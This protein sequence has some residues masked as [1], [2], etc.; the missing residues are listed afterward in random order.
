MPIEDN[1][2]ETPEPWVFDQQVADHF[3]DML[4]RSIPGHDAMRDLVD[5]LAETV[6]GRL[7]G[8]VLYDLGCSRGG[9][10][11]R[12]A[13]R[14]L[15]GGW[16]VDFVG[17]EVSPPMLAAAAARFAAAPRVR[18]APTDLRQADPDRIVGAS[19]VL[20]VLTLQFVPVE[21]R[22]RI[23]REAHVGLRQGGALILV[24]KVLG[25]E[26]DTNALLVERYHAMKRRNGYS[27]EA[28]RR[29]ALSLEGVLV[30]LTAAANEE[31]LRAAG[32]RVVE[33]FWRH[34]NFAGWIA[35]R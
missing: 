5:D 7:S 1:L 20:S 22:A 2:A 18:I 25:P 29:K 13:S 26:H 31:A 8:G 35:L 30:P 16:L 24:E 23:L 9:A 6:L 14:G 12:L 32:F 10:I 21:H 34:L 17:Y 3:D 19:V 4:R 33:P 27:D 11:A 15:A 28:I